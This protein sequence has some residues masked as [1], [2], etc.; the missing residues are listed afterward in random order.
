LSNAT[1][2]TQLGCSGHGRS[3]LR[4]RMTSPIKILDL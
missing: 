2:G 3:A 1:S 4:L